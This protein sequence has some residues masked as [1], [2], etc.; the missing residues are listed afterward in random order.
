MI[1]IYTLEQLDI[2]VEELLM[3]ADVWS[4][5]INE[6]DYLL[7]TRSFESFLLFDN[8]LYELEV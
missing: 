4:Y 3:D 5:P 7:E 1:K 8:R 2:D 6:L